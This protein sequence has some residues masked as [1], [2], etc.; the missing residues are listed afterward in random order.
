M[1]CIGLNNNVFLHQGLFLVHFLEI[2]GTF[3][4][5]LGNPMKNR[6]IYATSICKRN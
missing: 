3:F 4:Y 5:C 6:I 2:P 1:N